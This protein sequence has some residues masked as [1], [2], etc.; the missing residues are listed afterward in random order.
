MAF[1]KEDLLDVRLFAWMN[2]C[3]AELSNKDKNKSP[4]LNAFPLISLSGSDI[5]LVFRSNFCLIEYDVYINHACILF[6]KVAK[7]TYKFIA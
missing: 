2:V 3:C 6:K 5:W 4:A 1:K 7:I